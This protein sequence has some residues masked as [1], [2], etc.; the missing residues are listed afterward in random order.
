LPR[1][2]KPRLPTVHVS[3]FSCCLQRRMSPSL[4]LG[5]QMTIF[6]Q[7]WL[8]AKCPNRPF[9]TQGC[10][11]ALMYTYTRQT[12]PVQGPYQPTTGRRV[13]HIMQ[14]AR[15]A[16]GCTGKKRACGAQSHSP[17]VQKAESLAAPFFNYP[18][19]S[20]DALQNVLLA[21]IVQR[22]PADGCN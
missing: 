20:A 2:V 12:A 4:L 19:K 18:Q 22:Q 10:C 6:S 17:H 15:N 1:T 9:P 3:Y 21:L 5:E 11:R 13:A 14:C 7:Q 8:R 16:G